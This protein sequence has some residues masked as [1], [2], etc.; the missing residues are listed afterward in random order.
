MDEIINIRLALQRALLGNISSH[1]RVICCDWQNKTWFKLRCYL[2]IEPN[3][4]E[5]E[6][7]SCILTELETDLAFK[8]FYDEIIFTKES[9]DKLDRLKVVVY[10]RNETD[11]F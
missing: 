2:D 9:F 6:L 11:I 3:E 8:I 10:W 4:E 5:K 1:V 7:I